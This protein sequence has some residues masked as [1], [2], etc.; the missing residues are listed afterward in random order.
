MEET[1]ENNNSYTGCDI[2]DACNLDS[3]FCDT[4]IKRNNKN[5][6]EAIVQGLEDK[7]SDSG[8]DCKWKYTVNKDL[9][10][11]RAS[12]SYHVMNDNTGYYIGYIDFTVIIPINQPIDYKIQI[13][14]NSKAHRHANN[15]GL[16]EY[17]D[18]TIFNA[19]VED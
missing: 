5:A 1:E 9:K 2:C 16:R 19:I 7:A 12:N 10:K 13:N 15:T 14:G 17:L 4:C 11:I 6:I 8:I 3:V 18:N